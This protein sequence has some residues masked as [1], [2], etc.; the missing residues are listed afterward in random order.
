MSLRLYPQFRQEQG[1]KGRVLAVLIHGLGAPETWVEWEPLL[2]QDAQLE[3]VD[4]ALARYDTAHLVNGMLGGVTGVLKLFK[5][6]VTVS[7]D[8]VTD[9]GTLA[10]ELKRELDSR[11][12]RDYDQIVLIGHS[13]GG[14]VG[15]HY[16]L[17]EIENQAS[18]RVGGYLSLAT[19]FH[20]SQLAGYNKLVEWANQNRQIQELRPNGAFLDDTIRLW[21]KHQAT[22]ELSRVQFRFCYGV[23]DDIVEPT[24][25]LPHVVAS[26]WTGSIPLPGDHSGILNVS[27]GRDSRAYV[28]VRDH[29]LDVL[30]LLA[31][32]ASARGQG[33]SSDWSKQEEAP[34]N[35]LSFLDHA[36]RAN[37]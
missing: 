11:E 27:E 24:S 19:P 37:P 29:L 20:G 4:V 18:H 14:L 6:E 34:D 31:A 35:I 10:Q 8:N 2:L 32:D 13:M 23:Q 7:R 5:R 25:A 30:E 9:I 17:Q 3:G 21:M 33:D 12:Y 36:T 28:Q 1:Q 16:L 22:P 26:R 15:I